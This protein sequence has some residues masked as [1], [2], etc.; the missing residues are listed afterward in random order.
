MIKVRVKDQ[1]DRVK[2]IFLRGQ[3]LPQLDQ[4]KSW[5]LAVLAET[6]RWYPGIEF[7]RW[8]REFK[9]FSLWRPLAQLGR[10]LAD[11]SK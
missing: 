6:L 5:S 2:T 8:S 11:N 10:V 3:N 1:K 4:S 7:A 9:N